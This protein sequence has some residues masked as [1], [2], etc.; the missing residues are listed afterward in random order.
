MN[1]RPVKS[2]TCWED[3]YRTPTVRE[4][5]DAL[6]RQ[7]AHLIDLGRE[8]MLALGGVTESIEWRGIP[9]RWTLAFNVESTALAYLVPQP[10]RP[11][12]ALPLPEEIVQALPLRRATKAVRDAI[13][14]APRVG[15]ILWPAWDLQSRPQIE[16][17]CGLIRRK[18]DLVLSPAA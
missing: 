11:R 13:T 17:L 9:W 8:K 1:R 4:L 14:F 15:G 12:L 10:A 3:R 18:Y 7:H 6:S 5:C 16:E 2:R